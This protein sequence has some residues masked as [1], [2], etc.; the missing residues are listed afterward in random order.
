M[1]DLPK[2]A[3]RRQRRNQR[4]RAQVSAKQPRAPAARKEWYAETKARW[5]AFWAS[6]AA[7]VLAPA[8][9]AAAVQRLF[10]LYDERER[11]YRGFA[12]ARFVEGSQGQQ[13]L[14]PMGRLVAAFD[15][16]IR[17]LEDRLG[18]SPASRL[19]LGLELPSDEPPPAERPRQPSRARPD[20]RRKAAK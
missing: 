11:A 8:V 3:S 7:R 16:E 6:D 20:P 17:Q 9:D 1:R 13:V 5:K 14:N 18:F 2:D 4:G 15:G 12:K 10:D 19:R